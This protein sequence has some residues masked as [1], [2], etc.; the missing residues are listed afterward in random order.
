MSGHVATIN[1]ESILVSTKKLLGAEELNEF[2]ED[3]I[4][5]INSAIFILT[6]LGVGPET[7]FTVTS[8]E[9]TYEDYLGKDSP[10]IPQ[11][12]MYI[13]YKTKLGFDPPASS[14]VMEC[15]KEMIKESEYRLQVMCDLAI[16]VEGEVNEDVS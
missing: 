10:A 1:N 11:V 12:K 2:D 4:M 3:I 5:N 9:D 6:Q 15:I 8:A 16:D 14:A 13:Y 7:G